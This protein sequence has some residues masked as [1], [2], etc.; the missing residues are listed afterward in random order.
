[1]ASPARFRGVSSIHVSKALALFLLAALLVSSIGVIIPGTGAEYQTRAP[2]D[3]EIHSPTGQ[4]GNATETLNYTFTL[5]NAGDNADTFALRA[6]SEHDWPLN[7][8][9]LADIQLGP[10]E[11]APVFVEITIPAGVD[12]WLSDSLTLYAESTQGPATAEAHNR[13]TTNV[14]EAYILG[15]AVLAPTDSTPTKETSLSGHVVAGYSRQYSIRVGNLGNKDATVSLM[16]LVSGDSAGWSHVFDSPSILVGRT[17]Y[18]N[19]PS[20]ETVHL[21]VFAPA[22]AT[23]GNQTTC[24]IWAEVSTDEHFSW[25]AG[26][27]NLTITTSVVPEK[28]IDISLEDGSATAQEIGPENATYMFRITNTGNVQASLNVTARHSSNIQTEMKFGTTR[29]VGDFQVSIYQNNFDNFSVM[30]ARPGPDTP[31]GNYTINITAKDTVTLDVLGQF[32]V[33]YIVRPEIGLSMSFDEAE[34]IQGQ[35]VDVRVL[36]LNSGYVNAPNVTLTFFDGDKV[37]GQSYVSVDMGSEEESIFTWTPSD[38]GERSFNVRATVDGS[39]GDG[40]FQTYAGTLPL[41][42][43]VRVKGDWTPWA[44]GGFLLLAI[45]LG[46]AVLGAIGALRGREKLSRGKG[47][48]EDAG[49]DVL[50]GLD[51]IEN[52]EEDDDIGLPESILEPPEDDG[53]DDFSQPVDFD[54]PPPEDLEISPPGDDIFGDADT[55]GDNKTLPPDVELSPPADDFD[56]PAIEKPVPAKASAQTEASD[57]PAP[58]E[59]LD[60]LRESCG[61]SEIDSRACEVVKNIQRARALGVDT[62]MIEQLLSKAKRSM[63]EKELDK[64]RN[65]LKYTEDRVANIMERRREAEIAIEG[66][67]G[68]VAKLKGSGDTTVVENFLIRAQTLFE[69]GDFRESTSY[70]HKAEERAKRLKKNSR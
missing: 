69:Q 7:I 64:A 57:T 61:D 13:T 32:N 53:D 11:A 1:M 8:T 63:A 42:R 44:V 40:D 9:S 49:A 37:L 60:L 26:V 66:A 25:D 14:G 62:T 3:V 46:L 34:V 2:Y 21:D 18:P 35:S 70:A 15:L 17:Q 20:Y 36:L 65:Y 59:P 33:Y 24:V 30:V 43:T 12:A 29:F 28:S 23:I 5:K 55:D 67:R 45:I 4:T 39:A 47:V 38:F 10:G 31:P 16:T 68:S 6:E 50:V 51:D 41:E 22:N 27:S 58:P 19:A 54:I 56:P 52:D 48:D